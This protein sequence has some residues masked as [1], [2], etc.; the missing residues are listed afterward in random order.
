M[1][2]KVIPQLRFGV[3]EWRNKRMAKMNDLTCGIQHQSWWCFSPKVPQALI[4]S[5]VHHALE[6]KFDALSI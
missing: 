2:R 3:G 1:Q 5:S 4:Q 6:V